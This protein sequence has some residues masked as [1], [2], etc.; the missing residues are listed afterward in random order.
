MIYRSPFPDIEIP[1]ISLHEPDRWPDQPAL[2]DGT[3][4]RIGAFP[5]ILPPWAPSN[6]PAPE[7]STHGRRR[8]GATRPIESRLTGLLLAS[9]VRLFAKRERDEDASAR[10]FAVPVTRSSAGGSPDEVHDEDEVVRGRSLCGRVRSWV[11]G[12]G[13]SRC[14]GGS[15]V[16]R[17][18][19][20]AADLYRHRWTVACRKHRAE[21]G[22][23]DGGG[24]R[25]E[26]ACVTAGELQRL[27]CGS[28]APIHHQSDEW[29]TA[30]GGGR[31][32]RFARRV[33][34]IHRRSDRPRAHDGERRQRTSRLDP[35][36]VRGP[37]PAHR[38]PRQ[39]GSSP[40]RNETVIRV[41]FVLPGG[42][43]GRRVPEPPRRTRS[44]APRQRGR[45]GK[46]R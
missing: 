41:R 12:Q 14:G 5:T 40:A 4:V 37:E 42:A 15:G 9:R 22:V 10:G 18:V 7:Y 3:I 1:V 27:P 23:G 20:D 13:R 35:P 39:R 44:R 31:Q 33:G 43:P 30:R 28:R 38:T 21:R 46:S 32:S 8:C 17:S 25:H 19:P 45:P 2:I 26:G 11:G 6:S 16:R 24:H 36:R 29:R 34:R